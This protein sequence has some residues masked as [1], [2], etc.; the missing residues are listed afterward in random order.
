MSE[1]DKVVNNWNFGR[2][3]TIIV[4]KRRDTLKMLI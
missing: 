4:D 2:G 1:R 3:N